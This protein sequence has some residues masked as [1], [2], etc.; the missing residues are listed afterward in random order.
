MTA[1]LRK[2]W[3]NWAHNVEVRPRAIERPGSIEDLRRIVHD[4]ARR[5]EEIRAIGSGHSFAPVCA[6]TGVLLDLSL[7]RGV[8]ASDPE[9]GEATVL[10]GAKLH[11]LG[12]PLFAAGR[13]L[14]NQGDI[15]RQA[16]GGVV[17]TG[18][19]G[20]GRVAGSFSAQVT[21]LEL[22]TPEG[23]LLNLDARD[24]ERFRVARLALGML[25]ILS[26]V[27]VATVPAYKLRER[28]RA[29]PFEETLATYA[30][31]EPVVRNAEFWWLP[32]LDTGVLKTLEETDAAP[33]RP[34][35]REYPPGTLERY[36]KPEA[37]D[38]SWR[39]FPNQRNL[40]FV[41]LEYTLP[42]DQGPAAMRE[43]REVVRSRHPDCAWAVEYRTQPGE[44]ASISP[45][46]GRDS[47]TISVHQAIDL[48]WERYFRD[49][50]A[51]F[52]AHGGRP[53]WGKLHFLDA[54]QVGSLYP[55]L[56]AFER[57]RSDLDPRGVFLTDHL[58]GLGFGA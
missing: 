43:L 24:G 17:S 4:A 49:S 35:I 38:W 16:I 42:L 29:L 19:H 13:A 6:T 3:V 1:P 21:R 28:T 56:S 53:H 54:A 36:L 37:I 20:T 10:A 32:A 12:E 48:P 30:E 41:E 44:D 15:D 7:L 22:V 33:V 23:D 57:V 40:P 11:A 18:T 58:R 50:E 31:T 34:E 14:A 8:A 26:R 47:A 25:G 27:T 2:T 45:T 46:Q 39:I 9:T 5:S 51:V 52:L 55:G